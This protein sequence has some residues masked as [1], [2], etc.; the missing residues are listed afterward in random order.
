MNDQHP[1]AKCVRRRREGALQVEAALALVVALAAGAGFVSLGGAFGQGLVGNAPGSVASMPRTDSMSR[2]DAPRGADSNDVASSSQAGIAPV[3][4]LRE[5]AKQMGRR[6]RG[7]RDVADVPLAEYWVPPAA[8]PSR[9]PV[10]PG[11]PLRYVEADGVREIHGSRLDDIAAGLSQGDPVADSVVDAMFALPKEERGRTMAAIQHILDHQEVPADVHSSMRGPLQDY[12]DAIVDVPDWVD[13]DSIERGGDVMARSGVAGMITLFSNSLAGSY[14][15]PSGVQPLMKTGDLLDATPRRL[16]E[17]MCFVHGTCT[18]GSMRPGGE[19]WKTTARVRLIHAQVRGGMKRAPDFD[20]SFHGLPIN[21]TEMAGTNSAFST[22]FL[23]GMRRLGFH[24][25]DEEAQAVMD[26]WRYSGHVIGVDKKLLPK[27]EDEGRR[28]AAAIIG[29]QAA[30]NED[31]KALIHSLMQVSLLPQTAPAGGRAMQGIWELATQSSWQK[32]NQATT[33]FFL[34]SH[35]ADL[36]EIPKSSLEGVVRAL[37]QETA[38]QGDSIRRFTDGGEDLAVRTGRALWQRS[39]EYGL[40]K[41]PAEFLIPVDGRGVR[42]P[43]VPTS[44]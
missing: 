17:T 39:V 2:V 11:V 31:S 28:L 20:P 8:E 32:L 40:G 12:L 7:Y 24:Y 9:V 16:A 3:R 35:Y 23:D 37:W 42:S 10:R 36:L 27:T 41:D 18:P 15:S 44:R 26:L 4:W 43:Q 29:T 33:R 5:E 6:V 22:I 34:G 21:Q 1:S 13:W 14:L 30:P 25:T 38:H 19:A